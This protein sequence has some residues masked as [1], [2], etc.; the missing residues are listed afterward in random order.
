MNNAENIAK[1][2]NNYLTPEKWYHE[3]RVVSA[4]VNTKKDFRL[5]RSGNRFAG[6]LNQGKE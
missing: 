5:E 3:F 1:G 4:F 2:M 6:L